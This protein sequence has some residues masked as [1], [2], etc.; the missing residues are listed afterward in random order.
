MKIQTKKLGIAF[1]ALSLLGATACSHAGLRKHYKKMRPNMIKGNWD[2]TV[3]QMNA[4][5]T[6]IYG[7][8]DRIMFW[9]NLGTLQ[10][11][12]GQTKP[13]LANF[14]RAEKAMQDL[15]TTSVSAEASK[16]IAN[17]T[18][19]SYPGED[20]EKVLVY[21]YTSLSH[22]MQGY[23]QDAQVE[24]RA[25]D[26]LLQKMKI[27]YEKEGCPKGV[28]PS[29]CGTVYTQDAF[30]LWLVGLYREIEGDNESLQDALSLYIDAYRVY[31]N[32][33]AG[34]FG[35]RPP[36]FLPEDI[37]RVAQLLGR[38]DVVSE[39]SGQPGATGQTIENVKNG[40]G[41]VVIFH[42]NGES[43][44]KKELKFKSRMPD[45][46]MNVM[47]VPSFQA[48]RHR[49][50]YAKVSSGESYA[51]TELAEPVTAIA[52]K[53]F[54]Y[55]LPAIKARA[56]AR[57]II[58]YAATKGAQAVAKKAGGGALGMLVGLAGNI[59]SAATEAADLRSWTTLPANF[60]VGRLWLPAGDHALTVSYHTSTGARIGRADKINVTVGAGKRAIISVRSL[61]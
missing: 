31:M 20:H 5:K 13:S 17:E 54:E 18:A 61:R 51:Q 1:L 58:K 45:G 39:F 3:K 59:A 15:W 10:H 53:N 37:V 26:G 57:A 21:L 30:M 48:V 27:Y 11:Y 29:K 22:A 50:A 19:Q 9:L 25:A 34:N 46:F 52:L 38:T 33:Y 60:G 28:D 47:A 41:E 6:K 44:F 32:Q 43:P 7:E 35:T 12:A 56:V 42:G 55:R 49:I 14:V 4:A 16:F 36:S 2:V 23:L 40:M 8:K 24:A